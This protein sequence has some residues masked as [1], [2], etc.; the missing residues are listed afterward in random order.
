MGFRSDGFVVFK[1]G[2]TDE[3][4]TELL[5]LSKLYEAEAIPTTAG[6]H[7]GECLLK[8]V[9][10]LRAM[11]IVTSDVRQA[12]EDIG[13]SKPWP[14]LALDFAHPQLT[15]SFQTDA[16]GL[17]LNQHTDGLW[18]PSANY[19]AQC[20]FLLGVL[21]EHV[22]SFECGPYVFWPKSHLDAIDH[23]EQSPESVLADRFRT[24]PPA[25]GVSASFLGRAGDVIVAHRLLRH[26][27]ASRTSAGVRRMVFFRPGQ[28][29]L[30]VGA[31]VC[32]TSFARL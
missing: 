2:L 19:V 18:P 26:G 27:T 28:E 14:V 22:P 9:E 15:Y 23:L 7:W 29:Y 12:I 11:D 25:V 1:N 6:R 4:F 17:A 8:R 20:E 10:H 30:A 31:R 3:G 5:R 24:I 21:L 32:D 16:S 13:F